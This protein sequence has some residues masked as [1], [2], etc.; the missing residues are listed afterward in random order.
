MHKKRSIGFTD[1]KGKERLDYESDRPK[2]NHFT[3]WP[4]ADCNYRSRSCYR[5]HPS[6]SCALIGSDINEDISTAFLPKFYRLYRQA[7][8]NS[9]D[10]S[11]A[12]RRSAFASDQ[13]HLTGT[14][15]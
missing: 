10:C 11:V 5:L 8:R 6:I 13:H 1:D 3:H 2:S 12:D 15:Y 14:L 7:N 4:T 9:A